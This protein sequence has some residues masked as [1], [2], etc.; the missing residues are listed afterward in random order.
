[1]SVSSFVK[2]AA[3]VIVLSANGYYGFAQQSYYENIYNPQRLDGVYADIRNT[4]TDQSVYSIKTIYQDFKYEFGELVIGDY[5]VKDSVICNEEGK[6]L[7]EYRPQVTSENDGR[8]AI[9]KWGKRYECDYFPDSIILNAVTGDIR[10]EMGFKKRL[11]TRDSKGRIV[12]VLDPYFKTRYKF[13]YTNGGY[14]G[15]YWEG[16]SDRDLTKFS[17][18]GNTLTI[19]VYMDK[20]TMTLRPDNRVISRT[21]K[22]IFGTSTWSYKYNSHGDMVSDGTDD[23]MYEYDSYGNWVSRKKVNKRD[24][25][26]H[27]WLKREIIYVTPEERNA[28][29]ADRENFKKKRD[30]RVRS[31]AGQSARESIAEYYMGPWLDR[32]VKSVMSGRKD[33]QCDTIRSFSV[34]DDIYSFEFS[35]GVKIK[36][37]KF[38]PYRRY[39]YEEV[40]ISQ[41][42][43][44][45]LLWE[46][47]NQGESRWH[48]A[49]INKKAKLNPYPINRIDWVGKYKSIVSEIYPEDDEAFDS[50]MHELYHDISWT[51]QKYYENCSEKLYGDIQKY[52]DDGDILLNCVKEP[53]DNGWV[54]PD[55]MAH[56]E[57]ETSLVKRMREMEEERVVQ[58][59]ILNEIERRKP[60]CERAVEMAVFNDKGKPVAA[61]FKNLTLDDNSLIAVTRDKQTVVFDGVDAVDD[62]FYGYVG[63]AFNSN[64]PVAQK[65]Y[66]NENCDV[67]IVFVSRFIYPLIEKDNE[68]LFVVRLKDDMPADVFCI[69]GKSCKNFSEIVHFLSAATPQYNLNNLEITVKRHLNNKQQ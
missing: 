69:Q 4:S 6:V 53:Y 66:L 44:V 27:S 57:I 65:V 5:S 12:D 32:V 43:T 38:T 23:Y 26:I 14:T 41:D 1:M 20:N 7:V 63:S 2:C 59:R 36:G 42:T 51:I 40:F 34:K 37:M 11:I 28:I 25:K 35:D 39:T 30:D 46:W 21:R 17:R 52:L 8:G 62:V 45:I 55:C 19:D 24:G 16:T 60:M 9:R 61:N 18:N 64:V 56:K 49:K 29:N 47:S 33:M 50:S 67:A 13:T 3:A 22:F 31:L 58:Q 68:Y 48:V 10:K 54:S 15:E